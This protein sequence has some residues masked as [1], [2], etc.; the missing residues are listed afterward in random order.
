MI[1]VRVAVDCRC[2]SSL[3]APKAVGSTTWCFLRIGAHG[4]DIIGTHSHGS[5]TKW[6]DAQV[7]S[8]LYRNLPPQESYL[9]EALGRRHW[10]TCW[11]LERS[12]VNVVVVPSSTWH[13]YKKRKPQSSNWN[14]VVSITTLT[15]YV[16]INLL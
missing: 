12:A 4:T 9:D 15:T 7:S 2:Q 13:V 1:I 10:I 6:M 5:H 8:S 11:F 3:L 14:P 16:K